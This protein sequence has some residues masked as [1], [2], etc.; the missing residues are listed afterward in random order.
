MYYF[1]FADTVI[2]EFLSRDLDRAEKSSF[3]AQ[4]MSRSYVNTNTNAYIAHLQNFAIL[5]NK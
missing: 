5:R 1:D 4:T 3:C 2:G